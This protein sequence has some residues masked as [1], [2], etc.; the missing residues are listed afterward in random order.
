L[1]RVDNVSF[2]YAA[3]RK[4]AFALHDISLTVERG[5]L[6]GLLGPNGCGKTTLLALMAG[7]QRP[8][9]G[10]VALEGTNIRHLTR[11]QIA[12][13]VASV[14]QETHPAF[15]YSVMEMVLMGRHPHLGPFA[16]EAPADIAIAHEM[17]ASTGTAHLADRT[18][19]TLSGGEKQR[20]VIAAALAQSPHLLLLDE[21]TAS[22]DLGFQLDIAALLN[23][24]N[25]ERGV[26]MVLATHDLNLAAS[27]CTNVVMLRGGRVLAQGPTADVLN[28]AMVRELYGV[29]S[30]VRFHEGAG[31]LTVVP[32][33]RATT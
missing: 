22:L 1:L 18:Y 17:L 21:P 15:D 12:Q 25:H 11:R 32:V 31:H 26:S 9:R 8:E 5:S 20:V 29:E 6:T 14:P 28:A 16:L 10:L 13:R 19:M 23:R 30:D 3:R 2:G 27:L 4:P 7:V 33:R 24:L